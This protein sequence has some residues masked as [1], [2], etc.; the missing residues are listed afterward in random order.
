[1]TAFAAF[2]GLLPMTFSQRVG[3]EVWNPLGMTMVSGLFVS[4]LVT[5]V[6]VPTIYYSLEKRKYEKVNR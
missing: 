4:T 1:M 2:F 5:L 3:A 6:L